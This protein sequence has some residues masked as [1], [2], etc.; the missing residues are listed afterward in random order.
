[1]EMPW[2]CHGNAMEMPW[3]CHGNAWITS[4]IAATC[5]ISL[6]RSIPLSPSNK[7]NQETTT[8]MIQLED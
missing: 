5:M 8:S 1:M 6:I 2:K 7:I 3:K 4:Y